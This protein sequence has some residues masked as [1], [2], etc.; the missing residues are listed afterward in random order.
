L[1][2]L[3][4]ICKTTKERHYMAPKKAETKTTYKGI[5]IPDD[6]FARLEK[7]AAKN[8]TTISEVI[9][10]YIDKGL[11]IDGYT[12][13][14]DFIAGIVRQEVKAQLAPQIE[15]L[16]K[17]LM[18]SGKISAGQYYLMLKLL[19]QM[20]TPDRVMSLKELATETRKLGIRYMQFRDHEINQYLEDDDLVFRDLERL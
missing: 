12:Q 14:V 15:R 9:R 2:L 5:R 6:T 11:E 13:D 4:F 18:K 20:V 7:I 8:H 3:F 16:V 19:V 17:I 10:Q 1:N